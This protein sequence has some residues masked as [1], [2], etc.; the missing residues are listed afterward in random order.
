MKVG[1]KWQLFIP[2]KLA[3]GEEGAEEAIGPNAALIFEVE[4]LDAKDVAVTNPQQN[5]RQK[6]RRHLLR[7]LLPNRP[8][9]PQT[10]L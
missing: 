9:R 2:S 3:F 6:P 4:L 5:S 1:S 8:R 10:S 7:N